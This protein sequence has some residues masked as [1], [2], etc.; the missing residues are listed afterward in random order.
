MEH[1]ERS[2][3]LPEQRKGHTED[4]LRL[5]GFYRAFTMACICPGSKRSCH[6]PSPPLHPTMEEFLLT[7]ACCFICFSPSQVFVRLPAA[8]CWFI[9]SD[10]GFI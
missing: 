8:G 9:S 6:K 10:V 7:D 3:K 2:G 5:S 4:P 1:Q